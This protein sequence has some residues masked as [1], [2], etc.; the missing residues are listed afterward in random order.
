[1][2][3][4]LPAISSIASGYTHTDDWVLWIMY[5]VLAIPAALVLWLAWRVFRSGPRPARDAGLTW[6]LLG[7]SALCAGAAYPRDPE[8]L[9]PS[10]IAGAL[11]LG[12]SLRVR[13]GSSTLIGLAVAGWVVWLPAAGVLALVLR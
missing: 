8:L 13:G 9:V 1:M 3:P 7:T 10:L 12:C 5:G 4:N 11:A 6:L 2:R